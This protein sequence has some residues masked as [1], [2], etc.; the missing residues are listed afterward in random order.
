MLLLT[1]STSFLNGQRSV[2]DQFTIAVNLSDAVERNAPPFPGFIK[3]PERAA[4]AFCHDD[5]LEGYAL[6]R[7]LPPIKITDLEL[8]LAKMSAAE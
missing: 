2:P 3:D 8:S 5:V 6:N 4:S 7:V 1:R